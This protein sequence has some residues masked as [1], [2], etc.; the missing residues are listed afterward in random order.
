MTKQK[1]ARPSHRAG[2][3]RGGKA[4]LP[5]WAAAVLAAFI[6]GAVVAAVLMGAFAFVSERFSL[7]AAS[8]RP[9]ALAALW[10]AA[11]VSGYILAARLGRQ[12]LFCGMMCGVFYCACLLLASWLYAGCVDLDGANMALPVS[13]LLG[14]IVG[15][16]VSAIRAVPGAAGH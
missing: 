13:L 2:G 9:L 5:P 12:R 8:A 16:I 6:G 4:L 3:V 7:P 14:G 15:G 11:A 10:C 1:L